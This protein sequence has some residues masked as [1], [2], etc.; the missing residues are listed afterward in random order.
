MT[1]PMYAQLLPT[2]SGRDTWRAVRDLAHP[3]RGLATAALVSLTVGAAIGLVVPRVLGHVV[4][5]VID[6]HG[7][8]AITAPVLWLLAIGVGQAVVTG[9]GQYLVARL[10]ETLLAT[11]REDVVRRA[12]GLPLDQVERAGSGDLVS[13][14]SGDV[15]VIQEA[16]RDTLP[17]LAE[18]AL[19]VG[20]TVVGLAALDW[21]FALAGLLAAPIQIHTVRW[22]LRH[23]TP[24][25]AR[26]R[27]AEGARTQQLLDSIGG[28]DTV[29]A[30][31]LGRRHVAGV[32][33]C[34]REAVDLA[35]STNTIATRFYG[36]LNLAEYVG[37]TA[38]LL[39]G[40]WL[41]R[42]DAVTVGAAA[43]AALYFH[44]IFDPINTLLG[45]FGTA[46]EAAAGLARLVGI[47]ETEAPPEPSSDGRVE[48]VDVGFEYVADHPVL[49]GFSLRVAPGEHV[50]LVGPS[51]AGKTTL[52]KVV[53]GIHPPTFGTVHAGDVVL[54]TQEVHVFSG[55][56]ADD[57]RL[58]APGA[59]DAEL[60]T[61][62]HT[63]GA[64]TWVDL[65][66]DG[67]MTEVGSG[68]R[69]LT[70]MQAQQLALARLVLVDP[71][72]A[73]LDEATADAGSAGAR[74]LDRAAAAAL[75][76]RTALIVAHR[77]SQAAAADR[78]VVVDDGRIIEQG[79]HDDLVA[80]SG[81]YAELW[82]AW[83]AQR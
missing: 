60:R 57:L 41:V 76:G 77:L 3:H 31:R 13:R 44:R 22:Y 16:V 54:A 45:L 58:A 75:R 73:V 65:L 68:G 70:A 10:G 81:P 1:T 24:V 20:L 46:Q 59:T 80:T 23:S 55:S 14:V 63:V 32:E 56:I 43:A 35:L 5:L 34:S 83:S 48:L 2:A 72:V 8:G 28:A 61:A 74:E 37:L 69:D 18:A 38:V 36:R 6:G 47:P 25:F 71:R 51:G 78:I 26:E 50:A 12:L 53:A 66:P 4:D 17:G 49:R 15:S 33:A 64:D 7:A 52:A 11:L 27:I 9:A 29:R 39:V 40:F 21:R 67:V 62:L 82:R 19:T 42:D 79:S 30:Y